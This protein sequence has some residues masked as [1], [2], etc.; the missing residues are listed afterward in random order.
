MIIAVSGLDGAGK[1]TQIDCLRERLLNRGYQV[2]LVWAR[3]GYTP[4]F[5]FIKRLLRGL[6]GKKLVPSGQSKDRTKKLESPIIQK[7]WL[8]IAILDLILLWGLYVRLSSTRKTIVICDRYL[9]DTLLD[10]RSN[11]PAS[12][13]E[14]SILWKVLTA[15]TPDPDHSFL[16]WVPVETSLQRSIAKGEPFPDSKETLEW[17]LNAYMDESTFPLD[18]YTLI[19]GQNSI[20]KNSDELYASIKFDLA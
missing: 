7:L 12:N 13:A 8:T 19:D 3:G 17:R 5:E 9:D 2:K 4:G 16:F 11:F 20:T 15:I 6:I 14:E 10:F 1:S 18:K